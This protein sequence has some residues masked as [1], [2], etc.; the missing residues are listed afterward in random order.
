[1]KVSGAVSA[2]SFGGVDV[3]ELLKVVAFLCSPNLCSFRLFSFSKYQ[4]GTNQHDTTEAKLTALPIHKLLKPIFIAQQKLNNV[5]HAF[6]CSLQ[7]HR[8]KIIEAKLTVLGIY[9]AVKAFFTRWK[10][11]HFE[12][13]IRSFLQ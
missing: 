8:L 13:L 11:Q 10:L 3:C 12:K 5:I 9:S 6:C 7:C 4:R 1:M 2:I